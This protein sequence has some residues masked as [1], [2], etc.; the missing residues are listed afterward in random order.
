LA[1][2]GDY[3]KAALALRELTAHQPDARSYALLGDMLRRAGRDREAI[4]ALKEAMWRQR[5]AGASGRV[6]TLARMIL[7][8]DPSD[9]KV[10]RLAA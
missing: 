5:Q 3:R 9:A 10:A 1:R 4:A 7:A 2:E 6:R 8:I